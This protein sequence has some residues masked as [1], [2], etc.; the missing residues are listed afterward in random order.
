[1]LGNCCDRPELA[2]DLGDTCL[3]DCSVLLQGF[4]VQSRERDDA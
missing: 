4:S 1:M 3:C 2:A